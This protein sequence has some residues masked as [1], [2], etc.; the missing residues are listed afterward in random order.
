MQ[1]GHSWSGSA[2]LTD[3]PLSS[4]AQ[5]FISDRSFC[6]GCKASLKKNPLFSFLMVK[7][8]SLLSGN[9]RW[10]SHWSI[11][12]FNSNPLFSALPLIPTVYYAWNPCLRNIYGSVSLRIGHWS[13]MGVGIGECVCWAA[14][15]G[16]EDLQSNHFIYTAHPSSCLPQHWVPPQTFVVPLPLSSTS[17]L[18]KLAA[19]LKTTGGSFHWSLRSVTFSWLCLPKT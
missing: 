11:C 15:N 17:A 9:M 7:P 6:W 18:I 3:S 2:L 1:K 16:V 5:L 13:L 8:G 4:L 10:R 12:K 14:W 19:P